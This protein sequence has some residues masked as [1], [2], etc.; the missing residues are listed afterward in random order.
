VARQAVASAATRL[1]QTRKRLEEAE[2]MRAERLAKAESALRKGEERL[3]Y[4]RVRRDMFDRLYERELVSLLQYEEAKEEVAVR[5]KELEEAGADLKLILADDLSELRKSIAVAENERKEAEGK[6]KLALAGS[7][8]EEIEAATAELAR[9]EAERRH[10]EAQL[11]LLAVVSPISGVIIT[12]KLREK[13]GQHVEKG[14]LIA[15]VNETKTIT[16]EIAISE[17]NIRDVSLGQQ[18]VLKARAYPGTSFSGRVTAVAPAAIAGKQEWHGKVFRVMT[19]IDNPDRLLRPEMTGM[20]KI[21]CGA[22]PLVD[23]LTRRLAR[24]VRVEFWSW[25]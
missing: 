25:W 22:R 8:P 23:L 21:S 5:E 18:V 11:Q 14:E 9:Q 12:P 19:E 4:G 7:R 20:A 16:A 15:E 2:R 13:V 6:L 17:K 3:K 1:D 24:Y 10:L